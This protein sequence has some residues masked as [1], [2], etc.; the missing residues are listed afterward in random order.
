MNKEYVS[1]HVAEEVSEKLGSEYYYKFHH[2]APY[3]FAHHM[4]AN[5]HLQRKYTFPL[6]PILNSIFPILKLCRN[7]FFSF[8]IFYNECE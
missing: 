3:V 7:F 2:K 4:S 5:I 8:Q 1:F 6:T